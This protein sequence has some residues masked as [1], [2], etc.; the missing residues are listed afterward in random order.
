MLSQAKLGT[1]QRGNIILMEKIMVNENSTVRD[2]RLGRE[3][4]GRYTV[5][6]HLDTAVQGQS[7]SDSP[8]EGYLLGS[9]E[10][11]TRSNGFDISLATSLA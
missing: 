8:Q 1:G 10:C 2:F 5:H 9:T 11:Q 6:H 7:S 4:D 3:G